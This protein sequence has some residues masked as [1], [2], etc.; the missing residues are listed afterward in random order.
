[1]TTPDTV[2]QDALEDK[3]RRRM[4]SMQPDD[5]FTL[6]PP[7]GGDFE[8]YIPNTLLSVAVVSFVLGSVF[9]WGLNT[10]ITGTSGSFWWTTPQLGFFVASWAVFHFGEFATTAGW[11]RHVCSI[12][13]E[14][15][16]GAYDSLY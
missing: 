1:M 7:R 4:T 11:N 14:L 2:V 12:D 5:T 16:H 8:G 9:M 13:C 3:L 10:L 15:I 6:N